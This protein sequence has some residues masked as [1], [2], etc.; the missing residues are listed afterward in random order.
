VSKYNLSLDLK[1]A[2][3][4]NNKFVVEIFVL[5]E[6]QDD[7]RVIITKITDSMR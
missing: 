1:I 4:S 3:F 6:D 7:D 2:F 5:K